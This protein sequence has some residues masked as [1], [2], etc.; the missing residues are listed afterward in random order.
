[1]CQLEESFRSIF[2]TFNTLTHLYDVK[3]VLGLW[4]AFFAKITCVLLYIH[5]TNNINLIE[6][7]LKISGGGGGICMG[8]L[9]NY[10]HMRV[11]NTG[12]VLI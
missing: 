11:A 6:C 1:M 5:I 2:E 4:L 12:K 9:K 3:H 10:E 7:N 8:F